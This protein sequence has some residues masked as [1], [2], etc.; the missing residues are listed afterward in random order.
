MASW[1]A[2]LDMCSGCR[3]VLSD[4]G[5]TTSQVLISIFVLR[6]DDIDPFNVLLDKTCP[7]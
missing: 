5:T 2:F 4:D 7:K 6:S 1:I 3:C